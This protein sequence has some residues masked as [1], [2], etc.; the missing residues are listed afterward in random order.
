MIYQNRQNGF[1]PIVMVLLVVVGIGVIGGAVYLMNN[2]GTQGEK[3][4]QEIVGSE[5]EAEQRRGFQ[6]DNFSTGATEDLVIGEEVTV[7]GAENQDGSI[8][9]EMIFIGVP[10]ENFRNMPAFSLDNIEE[11][12]GRTSLPEGFDHEEFGNLSQEERMERMQEFRANVGGNFRTGGGR[13]MTGGAA[14]IRGEIINRDEMSITV[15]LV[16]S[17]SKLVFYFD[18]TQIRKVDKNNHSD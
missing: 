6:F 16:D 13:M 8:T 17:G 18:D 4:Q 3:P 10:E 2:K 7:R 5:E 15:K 12:T 14:F 1:A 9:A 11:N